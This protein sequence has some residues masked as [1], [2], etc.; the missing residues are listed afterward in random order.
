VSLARGPTTSFLLFLFPI[1]PHEPQIKSCRGKEV[2]HFFL[3]FLGGVVVVYINL[4]ACNPKSNNKF[5]CP[6]LYFFWVGE[7]FG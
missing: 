5:Y 3:F 1:L 6:I 7:V 4:N 2:D